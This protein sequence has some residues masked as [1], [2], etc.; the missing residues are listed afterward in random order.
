MDEVFIVEHD[1]DMR[2]TIG[3][4]IFEKDDIRAFSAADRRATVRKEGAVPIAADICPSTVFPGLVRG[5]M[6]QPE[7]SKPPLAAVCEPMY[8][9][10]LGVWRPLGSIFRHVTYFFEQSVCR[11]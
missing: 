4:R 1:A 8:T 5:V 2:R 6:Y 3:I 7:Q 11:L 9:A 10:F